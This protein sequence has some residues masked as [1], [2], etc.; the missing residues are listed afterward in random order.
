MLILRDGDQDD[1]MLGF[2]L[3]HRIKPHLIY[4]DVQNSKS[5]DFLRNNSVGKV[6]MLDGIY[7]RPE[8]DIESSIQI[9]LTETLAFCLAKDYEYAVFKSLFSNFNI[10][11]VYEILRLQGFY[12]IPSENMTNPILGVNMS[13]PCAIILDVRSYIKD[14]IKNTDSVSRAITKARKRMQNALVHLYPGNLVLSFNRKM[15][16]ESM[17]RKICKENNVPPFSLTPRQLGPAMCVPYGNILNKSVVPNTVTKSLHTEKMFAPDMKS[18]EI[19]AFPHYPDL[20]IQIRMIKSFNRPVILVD[21]LLHKGYRI[22]KLDPLLKAENIDVQKIVVGILSGRGKEL[23]DMQGREVETAY[24]IPKLKAWFTEG[25]FYPYIG[26]D[27]LWRGYF[28]QKNLLPSINLILPFTVPTFLPG[29]SKEALYNMSEVALENTLNIM[30]AIENEY[31]TMYERSLTLNSIGQ[32]L[33]IPRCPDHGKSMS[34]DYNSS[35][36]VYIRNDLEQLRR[37]K[38]I[39]L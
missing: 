34:Y 7:V 32:V 39:L 18:F 20:N 3:F 26:G 2:T 13:N 19:A 14:P 37:I 31:Q 6:L 25:S 21:D 17:T 23:M 12:E 27:A 8:I 36:S 10:K 28:S 15:L 16:Y 24:F 4:Q 9:L 22:K 33:T 29:T 11:K 38:N 35:P 30:E 5:S 1:K